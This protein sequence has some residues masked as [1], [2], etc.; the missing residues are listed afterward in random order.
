MSPA[1]RKQRIRSATRTIG[2]L[3]AFAALVVAL[4]LLG[5]GP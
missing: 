5:F 3:V 1:A 2:I 4:H